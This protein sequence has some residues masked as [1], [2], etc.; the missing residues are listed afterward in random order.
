[1]EAY[2]LDDGDELTVNV[3]GRPELTGKQVIGPDGQI[4]L[5]LA[6]Q[7]TLAGKTREEARGAI[8]AALSRYYENLAVTVTV[9]RYT[10]FRIMI[11]VLL[12]YKQTILP[13]NCLFI[14]Q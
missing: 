11:L 6:G 3:W 13:E 7:I 2:V 5:P 12:C 8:A 14:T 9:D 4:S 10:S 1:M